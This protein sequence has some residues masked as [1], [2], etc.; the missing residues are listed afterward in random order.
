MAKIK[1]TSI[2][3]EHPVP[4]TSLKPGDVFRLESTTGLLMKI[5]PAVEWATPPDNYGRWGVCRNI[6][7]YVAG[8]PGSTHNAVHITGDSVG[9]LFNLEGSRLVLL[10]KTCDLKTE[11]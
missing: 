11:F 3:K 8:R 1:N 9:Y 7:D 5:I 10:A 4:F 6:E 2:T